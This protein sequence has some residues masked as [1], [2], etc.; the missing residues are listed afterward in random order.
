MEVS[1]QLLNKVQNETNCGVILVGDFNF[2]PKTEKEESVMTN[3]GF[4]DIMH[5]FIE[6]DSFTMHKTPKFPPWRPDKITI[7]VSSEK[8]F[9]AVS[10]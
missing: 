5:D 9:S 7:P 1:T 2:D 10:A 6:K 4:R 3:N 8:I